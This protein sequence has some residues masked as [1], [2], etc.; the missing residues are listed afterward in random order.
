VIA[1]TRWQDIYS[2]L[3]GNEIHSIAA[4]NSKFF[5]DFIGKPFTVASCNAHKKYNVCLIGI[6]RRADKNR[7]SFSTC[8]VSSTGGDYSN[9]S[10]NEDNNNSSLPQQTNYINRN[11]LINPGPDYIID[12]DD[13]CFYMSLIKE[14]NYTMKISRTHTC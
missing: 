13:E 9:N 12:S 6:G 4:E 14:E 11:I 8:S 3:A 1:S 5:Q 7:V 2:K 10:Q